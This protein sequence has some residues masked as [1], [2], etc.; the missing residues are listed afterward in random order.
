MYVGGEVWKSSSMGTFCQHCFLSNLFPQD[1][2]DCFCFVLCFVFCF[3]INEC[4]QHLSC[5]KDFFFFFFG[6]K[7]QF[8]VKQLLLLYSLTYDTGIYLLACLLA[9][10]LSYLLTDLV[11]LDVDSFLGEVYVQVL[12]GSKIWVCWQSL[13]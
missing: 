2:F 9:Y 3:A 8:Q 5:A 1:K 6:G 13:E 7:T 10:L 11:V 4:N 12:L